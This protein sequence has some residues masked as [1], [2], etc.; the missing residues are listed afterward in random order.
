ML[1][2]KLQW[3]E[4]S[5]FFSTF[6]L[7]RKISKTTNSSLDRVFSEV[8]IIYP[9]S[10]QLSIY[11]A[12][13]KREY[14]FLYRYATFVA[15]VLAAKLCLTLATP[16]TVARQVPL[17]MGFSR[18][19]CWSGLPF[20]SLRDLPNPGTE[21]FISCLG[22]QILYHRATWEAPFLLRWTSNIPAILDWKIP[23][24]DNGGSFSKSLIPRLRLGRLRGKFR[25]GR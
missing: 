20:P 23:Q 15:V 9:I 16:W 25:S 2:I 13:R 3:L 21:P 12:W 24:E 1:Q 6:N 4:F 10:Y 7:E 8:L 17:S 22:R 18:Q 19:E 14:T 5:V 11:A